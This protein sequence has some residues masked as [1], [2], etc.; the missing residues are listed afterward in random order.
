M[1]AEQ[2][3]KVV[4]E[5]ISE[6]EQQLNSEIE[7]RKEA[8]ALVNDRQQTGIDTK[9]KLKAH[10]QRLAELEQ[11]LNAEAAA[12]QTTES[13]L[14]SKKKLISQL[15]EQLSFY[16]QQLSEV[17][18]IQTILAKAEERLKAE[19]QA[20]L[21]AEK[22]IETE[23]E[24]RNLMEQELKSY[25]EQFADVKEKLITKAT[26][27]SIAET[28]A[29]KRTEV[30]STELRDA[31]IPTGTCECCDRDDIKKSELVKINS[32][33]LLCPQCLLTLKSSGVS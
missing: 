30:R 24:S 33:Q 9:E 18:D 8:E 16:Q 28:A 23:R 27:E 10:I 21:N 11:Q 26:Q 32:G 17:N 4:S 3:L 20:R 2:K 31:A 1:E 6:L 15:Q 7:A 29:E 12:R 22:E 25:A 5:Q 14:T 13:Q 19:T